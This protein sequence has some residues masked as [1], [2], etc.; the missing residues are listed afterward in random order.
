[1]KYKIIY[2]EGKPYEE[3][4]NSDPELYNALKEFYERNKESDYPYDVIVYDENDNEITD[5]N[6]MESMVSE[7][8]SEFE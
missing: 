5:S 7:I 6:F 3:E 4:Y 8:I 1:M 2:I